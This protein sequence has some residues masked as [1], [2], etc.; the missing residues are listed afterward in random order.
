M[1][2]SIKENLVTLGGG[3]FWCLE[4][5]FL[6]IEGVMHVESGYAGGSVK[7]PTYQEVC[8]GTTGHAE[9]I[10]ISFDSNT[11]SFKDLLYIFFTIHDPT[12]LNKQGGDVGTQ[13]RSIVLYHT[14]EQRKI[15]E[16]VIKDLEKEEVWNNIVTEI[17]PLKE[18]FMAEEY[19]QNYY[20]RNTNQGYC[21]VVIAPKLNKFRSKYFNK[22]KKKESST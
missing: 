15:S 16:Q 18:Y 20:S 13:Y 17:T 8:Q 1:V 3:C 2:D 5:V 12:T 22:F 21:K 4:A 9:V 19:H 7:D 11:V 6:E 10:Q 14:E